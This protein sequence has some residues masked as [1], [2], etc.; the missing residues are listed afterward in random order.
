M[1]LPTTLSGTPEK[2]DGEIGRSLR[3]G[4]RIGYASILF[5]VGSFAAWSLGTHLQGAI[6]TGGQF[7]VASD[8][9]KV[10]HPTGGVVGELFVK[11]GQLVQEGQIVLR[12]DETMPRANAQIVS[13]QLDEMG[14]RAAR[15]EAERDGSQSV[16][17][18]PNLLARSDNEEVNRLITS[19][20][21]L[22]EIRRSAKDGQRSQLQKRVLQLGDEIRGLQAQKVAKEREAQI[23]AGEL[24]GVT[25]LYR[26]NLV[27]ISRLTALQRQAAALDGQI[28]QYIAS[29]AQS[30]G[31]ISEIQLQIIQLDEDMRAEAMKELREIQGKSAELVERKIAAE[32]QLRRVE[33]RS[34]S[35]GTVHQLAVHTVGGV[36]QPGEI[37]MLIVP[38]GDELHMEARVSPTDI[39]QVSIGQTARVKV[40]AGNR[41]TNPE[42]LGSI[43]RVAADVSKDDKQTPPFYS[44]RIMIPYKEIERLG[45]VKILPGMQA[46]VFIETLNR[47]PL[48]YFVKPMTDHFGRMFRER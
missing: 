44:V 18:P 27:Q 46:E 40:Q 24:E 14:I 47:T 10:Q 26:Q 3:F 28:G 37:A 19:E 17:I 30:E 23:I 29:I 16:L 48:D 1:K 22:F 15:L 36:I 9:K 4:H 25:E 31:K 13:K 43:I 45:D 32:D 7:V 39:D 8:V 21:R 2:D 11:D 33:M 42:L 20:T 35:T 6:N 5:F 12:L 34:P 41:S 38:S